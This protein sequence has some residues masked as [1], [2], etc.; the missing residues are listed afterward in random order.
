M[1]SVVSA[2]TEL[3]NLIRTIKTIGIKNVFSFDEEWEQKE[4]KASFNEKEITEF[5]NDI[6]EEID[7]ELEE[8]LLEHN[9]MTVNELL[10][11]SITELE[12]I[13]TIIDEFISKERDLTE[14]KVL[15]NLF[16]KLEQEGIAFKKFANKL[17][18]EDIKGTNGRILFLL[19]MNME[20]IGESNDVILETL[21]EINK[22]RDEELDIAIVYSNEKLMHYENHQSKTK[23]IE[24]TIQTD[25]IKV[26]ELEKYLMAHQLW[27]ISKE[28]EEDK[29]IKGLNE[30]LSKAAIGNSLYYYLRIKAKIMNDAI[31]ELISL[32]EQDFRY[33]LKDALIE[34]ESIINVLQRLQQSLLNKNEFIRKKTDVEYSRSISDLLEIVNIANDDIVNLL[35]EVEKV[36]KFK[37]QSKKEKFETGV[38]RNISEY[39]LVDYS[40]N[41]TYEDISTGDIFKLE[42]LGDESPSYGILITANCDIPIRF[43]NKFSEGVR[44][45]EE[46]MSLL[47]FKSCNIEDMEKKIITDNENKLIW[48]INEINNDTN[49][50]TALYPLNKVLQI[51]SRILDI[52]T[53]ND[54][55]KGYLNNE[56]QYYANFK[57]YHF[58]EYF[59]TNIKKW[60]EEISLPEN[61]MKDEELIRNL[62]EMKNQYLELMIGL[63]YNI[64][65]DIDEN[66]FKIQRIGRLETGITL[67]LLQ[68]YSNKIGRVGVESIPF[69]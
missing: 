17:S 4:R 38:F 7:T 18:V 15:D 45:N 35:K 44:R 57:T 14:L 59:K 56:G 30:V 69:L 36:K 1:N 24:D 31:M 13:K 51:D 5:L 29:L 34:G 2:D 62:G 22:F 47:L 21:V 40:V 46:N 28:K 27:A 67:K 20:H 60:I 10:T 37:E 49:Y 12:S 19:D 61:Y 9:I 8:L 6:G 65:F 42:V 55:G 64:N 26:N 66:E 41:H 25:K 33:L 58:K 16:K 11:S 63:K 32:S 39:G 53:V 48:P 68:N 54:Q 43:G 23:Y 3:D 50:L 52:C